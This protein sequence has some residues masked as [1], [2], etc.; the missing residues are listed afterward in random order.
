MNINKYTE[1]C[2]KNG[3]VFTCDKKDDLA[4]I[5]L[6][7]K[8]EERGIGYAHFRKSGN[9]LIFSKFEY[10][11]GYDKGLSD[12]L[13]LEITK[14]IN[15]MPDSQTTKSWNNDMNMEE[16]KIRAKK[17]GLSFSRDNDRTGII[18][19]YLKLVGYVHF[20]AS[21]KFNKFNYA[22]G[23]VAITPKN[24]IEE[25]TKIIKRITRVK[26]TIESEKKEHEKALLAVEKANKLLLEIMLK[27]KKRADEDEWWEGDKG[28]DCYYL[29]LKGSATTKGQ[30][31][32]Y[33]ALRLD[34]YPND[35]MACNARDR[36]ITVAFILKACLCVD[37]DHRP[38]PSGWSVVY[39]SKKDSW[40]PILMV[41]AVYVGSVSTKEKAEEVAAIMERIPGANR[42]GLT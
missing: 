3:F 5:S 7:L 13:V 40:I 11:N 25:I 20:D 18:V 12:I 32:G 1:N 41:S 38:D 35:K 19:K 33:E 36:L 6:K 24:E 27:R 30:S 4:V 42:K 2:I 8:S 37:P 17:A 26:S 16:F 9:E 31:S 22:A 39:S 23:F 34:T 14:K 29:N 21:G 28:D 10:W 15:T